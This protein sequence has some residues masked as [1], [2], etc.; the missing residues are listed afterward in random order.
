MNT[1]TTESLRTLR[2]EEQD[3]RVV[4]VLPA[5]SFAEEHIPGSTSVPV[6]SEDFASRVED[7]VGGKDAKV[8]VYCASASCDASPRAARALEEAG[9]RH[10]YDY[11]GGVQA[12]RNAGLPLEGSRTG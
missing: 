1:L 7:Q 8:V 11:E 2:E 6:E 12:W 4:N 3:L 5:K 10:V 9:F